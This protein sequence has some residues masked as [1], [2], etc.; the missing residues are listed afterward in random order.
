M[1][2][3][4]QIIELVLAIVIILSVLLQQRGS[5]MGGVFGSEFSAYHSRRGFEKFL[6]YLTIVSGVLFCATALVSIYLATR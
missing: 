2:Q 4:L 5:G 3:I 6:Y 1:G